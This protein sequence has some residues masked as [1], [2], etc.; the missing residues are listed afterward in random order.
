MARQPSPATVNSVR[1]SSST[2]TPQP[3]R[4]RSSSRDDGSCPN[5][6]GGP[7]E[8]TRSLE[9]CA[10]YPTASA[11]YSFR[12]HATLADFLVR[13][14]SPKKV[15]GSDTRR[16]SS[17]PNFKPAAGVN[18]KKSSN[19]DASDG[20]AAIIHTYAADGSVTRRALRTWAELQAVLY[21][22]SAATVIATASSSSSSLPSSAGGTSLPTSGLTSTTPQVAGTIIYLRGWQPADWLTA[23]GERYGVDHEFWRRH[24][25]FGDASGGHEATTASSS[26]P[27]S[28][29]DTGLPSSSSAGGMVR[30]RCTTLGSRPG[31]DSSLRE[32]TARAEGSTGGRARALARARYE[33]LALLRRT[34]ARDMAKYLERVRGG[35]ARR[36]G[37]CSVEED[38]ETAR[39]T[40]MPMPQG[41]SLIRAF[42]L[43]DLGVFSLEQD[44]SVWVGR[45][46]HYHCGSQQSQGADG[47]AVLSTPWVAIVWLDFGRPLSN[48]GSAPWQRRPKGS[49]GTAVAATRPIDCRPTVQYRPGLIQSGC[50]SECV[51][52][53]R[54]R[55]AATIPY[56]P[57]P[58]TLLS[59]AENGDSIAQTACLLPAEAGTLLDGP[60]AASY[61]Y[62]ALSDVFRFAA[63]AEAQFLDMATDVLG[64]DMRAAD[65]AVA[66][67]S[68]AGGNQAAAAAAPKHMVMWSLLYNRQI[69]LRHVA[70]LGTV[71][72]FMEDL[73][74]MDNDNG[75]DNA[76]GGWY[77][78]SAWVPSR[79]KDDAPEPRDVA[80]SMAKLLLKDYR[81]LLR[82]AEQLTDEYHNSMSMLMNAASIDESQRAISQAEGVANLTALAF[83]FVPLSFTT[84]IFGMNFSEI[85]D[86]SPLSIWVWGVTALVS[87]ILSLAMLKWWAWKQAGNTFDL[88]DMKEL[89]GIRRKSRFSNSVV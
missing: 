80:R 43:H 77:G 14:S 50:S 71:V 54:K 55:S 53:S 61:P 6:A 70:Q 23:I 26:L 66:G 67:G 9:G 57:Q 52:R 8:Y 1:N 47:A 64:R 29:G 7:S 33:E 81:Y 49:K 40:H 4:S 45:D 37:S 46:S 58:Q 78:S 20:P 32:R 87:L 27:S 39:A 3:Y 82:R 35:R 68:T 85:S 63:A 84:S 38:D 21:P 59:D 76:G 72:R 62:Y 30:L 2:L 44:V 56:S 22:P 41:Q 16:S 60:T 24:L 74:E 83:V 34:A 86:G 88:A 48:V 12:H 25:D 15:N 79:G 18:N 69:L 36:L 51:L 89:V 75:Y 65:S 31:D 11:F 42:G 73:D 19:K 13:G 17:T 5:G 10:G 28:W